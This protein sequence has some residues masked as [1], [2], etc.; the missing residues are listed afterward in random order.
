MIRV[1]AIG[2]LGL[3]GKALA[4]PVME[5][6]ICRA[7]WEAVLALDVEA[8]PED[9]AIL[10]VTEDG[11]CRIEEPPGLGTT[12]A[13]EWRGARVE[14]A[15]SERRPPDA[16]ELRV[17]TIDPVADLGL[18]FPDDMTVP[19]VDFST[20]VRFGPQTL[21]REENL[22]REGDF[23]EIIRQRI[24]VDDLAIEIGQL[25]FLRAEAEIDYLDV[26]SSLTGE[27]ITRDARA[28][29]LSVEIDLRKPLSQALAAPLGLT[30]ELTGQ[31]ADGIEALPD[32]IADEVSRHALAGFLKS[33]PDTS[34]RFAWTWESEAWNLFSGLSSA[35]FAFEKSGDMAWAVNGFFF[36]SKFDARWAASE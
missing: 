7:G 13:I 3:S 9:K 32:D 27:I 12:G 36:A 14:Q 19:Y 24:F 8:Q 4:E 30:T 31:I 5:I 29:R 17:T 35:Q 33:L 23:I 25:G 26:T 11:W 6:E 20:S 18:R 22:A 2:I 21:E 16:I 15:A 1:I 28:N 10:S 34:G